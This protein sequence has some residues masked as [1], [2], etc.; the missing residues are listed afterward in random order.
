MNWTKKLLMMNKMSASE[1]LDSLDVVK[2][3]AEIH[4]DKQ[5]NV[6]LNELIRKVEAL[7][8]QNVRQSTVCMFFE[9]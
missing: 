4:G 1:T 8:V 6:V 7:K 5:I 9:K 3:F 2:C